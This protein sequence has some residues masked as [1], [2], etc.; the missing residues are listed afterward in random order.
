M[1]LV[2]SHGLQAAR[3]EIVVLDR[4]AGPRD[5]C[6]L[7]TL[8]RTHQRQLHVERQRGG[9]AVRVDLERVQTFRLDE[10]LVRALLGEAHDLVFDRRTVARADAFDLA[11]VQRRAIQRAADD[12][13]RVLAGMGDPAA[14]LARVLGARAQVGEHRR[15]DRRPA[16]LPGRRNRCCAH[17]CAAAC[18]SSGGQPRQAVRA[19]SGPACWPADRR[20]GRQRTARGRYG[21]CRPERCRR[22]AP[23]RGRWNFRP[24]WVDD[25]GDAPTFQNQ[26]IHRLLEQF[27]VRLG[28]HHVPDRRL[29]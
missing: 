17:R 7:E 26:V 2:S 1:A 25:A 21:S 14:D 9:D 6:V 4:I 20:R 8:D 18:R 27:Q 28:F 22:S 23:Q 11:G 29:V 10:D 24:I 3:I 15:W 5:V 16:A 19:A 13:V 12:L